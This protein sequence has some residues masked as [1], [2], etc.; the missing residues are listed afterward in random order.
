[1]SVLINFIVKYWK[2]LLIFLAIL[3]LLLTIVYLIMAVVAYF[4]TWYGSLTILFVLLFLVSRKIATFMVFPGHC[5]FFKRSIEYRLG[6]QTAS[7]VVGQIIEQRYALE[8]VWTN[9][10]D[11]GKISLLIETNFATCQMIKSIEYTLSRQ[12]ELGTISDD[13]ELLHDKIQAL[14]ESFDEIKLAI[15]DEVRTL[16]EIEE[17]E[18]IDNDLFQ[19]GRL[20]VQNINA[21]K[22]CVQLCTRFWESFHDLVPFSDTGNPTPLSVKDKL[23]S[24]LSNTSFGTIDQLRVELETAYRGV[25]VTLES[26]DGKNI[27]WMWIPGIASDPSFDGHEDQ[28]FY[29]Y[30]TFYIIV[31]LIFIIYWCVSKLL[32]YL[33]FFKIFFII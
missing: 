29:I 19:T 22:D 15:G 10:A 20:E 30:F 23:K 27:D 25:Q 5:S 14:K 4:I 12:R 21:V 3:S 32:F 2:A 1:M 6:K 18:S 26:E 28:F 9:T 31:L 24:F 11:R 13:Q 8:I 16:W 17:I 7:K 33:Y